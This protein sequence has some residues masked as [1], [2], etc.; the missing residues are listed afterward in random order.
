[1]KKL[2]LVLTMLGVALL[3]VIGGFV[4]FAGSPSS[5][6]SGMPDPGGPLPTPSAAAGNQP[7]SGCLAGAHNPALQDYS[8]DEKTPVDNPCAG[9][10][11]NVKADCQQCCTNGGYTLWRCLQSSH[12]CLCGN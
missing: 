1:V 5:T 4:S 12:I 11:C 8:S 7:V 2:S 9:V 10:V 3:L 6:Q